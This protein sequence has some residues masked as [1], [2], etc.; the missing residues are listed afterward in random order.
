MTPSRPTNALRVSF[1]VV[2]SSKLSDRHCELSVICPTNE[3]R[4]GG[5]P[6]GTGTP[7]FP[8]ERFVPQSETATS[9]KTAPWF[10]SRD[11]D[12]TVASLCRVCSRVVVPIRSRFSWSLAC[13]ACPTCRGVDSALAAPHGVSSMIPPEGQGDANRGTL[14]ECLHPELAD[15]TC[16]TE[17]I[18]D[19]GPRVRIADDVLA[20]DAGIEL[21]QTVPRGLLA[22]MSGRVRARGGHDGPGRRRTCAEHPGPPDGAC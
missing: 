1:I 21:L 11:C 15:R 20:R 4:S 19:G 10:R 3:L 8:R 18:V 17:T 16:R 14:Y 7:T 22:A 12:L 13:P 2:S 9:A 5:H 6:A